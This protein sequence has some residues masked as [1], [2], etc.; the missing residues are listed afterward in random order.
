MLDVRSAEELNPPEPETRNDL[1]LARNDSYAAITG[2]M[3]PV[4][5]FDSTQE[6]T[7]TRSIADSPLSS[8][9]RPKPGEIIT[10]DPLST[11][12]SR[13]PMNDLPSPL[14]FRLFQPSGSKR[15]AASPQETRLT[16]YPIAV[17]DSP[18]NSIYSEA[19]QFYPCR[20][21]KIES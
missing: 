7:R 20:P 8:V 15:S 12:D 18:P 21:Q 9:S 13:A 6:T 4:C 14:P 2:S 3:L 17:K 10:L 19:A 5:P 16:G 1:S 11:P